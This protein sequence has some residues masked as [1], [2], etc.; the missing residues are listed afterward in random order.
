MPNGDAEA[1]GCAIVEDVDREAME[2]DH[3]GE[4]IDDVRDI[5]EAGVVSARG[6]EPGCE[7]S[8]PGVNGY[9][10]PNLT[11]FNPTFD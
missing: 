3:L 8:V 9:L 6:V 5:L 2:T 10:V 4:A 1:D 7:T 11:D